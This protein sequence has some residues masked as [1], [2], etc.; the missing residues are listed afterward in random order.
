MSRTKIVATI[1]PASCR[2]EILSRLLQAGVDVARLN[3]SHG[4]AEQ[5]R[6][7]YRRLRRAASEADRPLAVLQDLAGPK[8]GTGSFAGHAP[9]Q[10][11]PESSVT[12]T[13]RPV[14]GGPG[15]VP[16]PYQGL[17]HDV[18]PGSHLLLRDG[19]IDLKVISK[20][21]TDVQCLVVVGGALG[22]QQGINLPG[23]V[24]SAPSVT[25]KDYADLA[26]GLELGVDFV[27]LSFVRQPE[28]V[29]EVKHFITQHGCRVPLIA[30]IEKPQAVA[31]IDGIVDAA[32]GLMIARGDLGVE[33]PLERVPLVQKEL[34]AKANAAGKPVITATQMLESMCD[35]PRPTRAEASDVANAIL[36]GTD[37]VML[38]AETAAG[39]FPVE[40]VGVMQRIANAAEEHLGYYRLLHGETREAGAF[41]QATAD[42]ACEAA[43]S[44][45]ADAVVVFTCSGATAR[46]VA[47]RRPRAPILAL[48]PEERTCSNLALAWGV[49]PILMPRQDNLEALLGGGL[50]RLRE[51]ELIAPDDVAVVVAG[52]ALASGAANI[53]RIVRV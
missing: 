15:L 32:D 44:L 22:E 24:I 36:D 40:A 34:I 33:L 23:T 52:T 30:K 47:Q 4:T 35:H 1:G 7:W 3:F 27:A 37:A 49:T 19:L 48:T 9:I 46:W 14:A 39:R 25:E 17:P 21:E 41:S 20:S 51:R 50:E 43:E 28:D 53:V 26:V 31:N 18:R 45:R 13:T 11:E 2:P 8:I 10:L 12:I 38:S 42:A 5:H 16:T 29:L 6:Q